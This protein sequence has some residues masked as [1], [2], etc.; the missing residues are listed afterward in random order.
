MLAAICLLSSM[1]MPSDAGLLNASIRFR[2]ATSCT[3]VSPESDSATSFKV[4]FIGSSIFLQD[5]RLGFEA[6]AFE[7]V[8]PT[9]F[10][11][12]AYGLPTAALRKSRSMGA[13]IVPF[14]GRC[15]CLGL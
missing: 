11:S 13:N 12:L 14:S 1:L 7:V 4:H 10:H 8:H 2:M 6:T 3:V 5:S 15:R 9:L